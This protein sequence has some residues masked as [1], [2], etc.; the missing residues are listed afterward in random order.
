MLQKGNL[1]PQLYDEH[2]SYKNTVTSRKAN[3][4]ADALSRCQANAGEHTK[5]LDAVE[6]SVEIRD[7]SNRL[8]KLKED[9]EWNEICNE[10]TLYGFACKNI[11]IHCLPFRN[12]DQDNV[13]VLT[14]KEGNSRKLVP[15]SK[16]KALWEEQHGGILRFLS[17]LHVK[18]F[19]EWSKFL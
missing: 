14:D 18:F 13:L 4:V 3:V 6:L 17:S 7:R 16:R 1:F 2:W 11:I 12:P 5:V 10:I 15:L 9:T 8:N 19:T